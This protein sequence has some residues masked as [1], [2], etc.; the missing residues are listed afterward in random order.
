MKPKQLVYN[1]FLL[2]IAGL[3]I[4]MQSFGQNGLI[5]LWHLDGNTTDASGN[6]HNGAIVGTVTSTAG[7]FNNAYHFDGSSAID[8]GNVNLNSTGEFSVSAWV[9]S[10][11][12]YVTEVW[13]MVV[14]KLNTSTG[15]PLELFLGD[16]RSSGNPGTAGNYLAWNGG[17]SLYHAFSPYDLSRNA[18]D[19]NWH[20]L[21][22]TF[23]S[24]S[25]IVYFNGNPVGSSTSTDPLPNT[26]SNFRIG[27][28][29][30]G[31]YH[32]P[33][34]GEID[35]VSAYNRVL[36][37]AEIQ[38][39]AGN[40]TNSLVWKL[41][42]NSDAADT[43]KL[44]TT[45]AVPLNIVTNNLT[46]LRILQNGKIG[47]NTTTPATSFHVNGFGAFGNRVTSS[48]ATRA[49]NL[50]DDNAVIRVLRVH[51]T[52]AP[53]IE[54]IS[55]TSADGA[56]VAYWDLYAQP[57][58]ASFRIRDRQ[59]GTLLDRL[60]IS[61]TYGNVGIGTTSPT[62]SALL[63]VS[64]TTKGLLTPRMTQ[65][66]RNAI[67]SPAPG[68]L[69]FQTDGTAGF[70][71]YYNGWKVLVNNVAT[72]TSIALT[73]SDN[74]QV[75]QLKAENEKLWVELA[76][77]KQMVAEFKGERLGIHNPSAY[78]EQNAPNPFSNKTIIRYTLPLN[79]RSANLVILDMTG[80][81][82][83]TITLNNKG[84][85]GQVTLN[86]GTLAAG[87]YNY[88]LYIENKP[89]DTRRLVLTR[90]QKLSQRRWYHAIPP[91]LLRLAWLFLEY[92][93]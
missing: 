43:S 30:F 63:D 71:Y 31:P 7:K 77:L 17:N 88:T 26:N 69:V 22:V 76:A 21:A 56:N 10:N 67:P 38:T 28:I 24:G 59:A 48:N 5:G 50:A 84:G 85:T 27:G 57:S 32:H 18:R 33:W 29:D 20:H 1:C 80:T 54:L 53:A 68:L 61:H 16:G 60:T 23:K 78:L 2:F 9:K 45:N 49:L 87:T 93:S 52:S 75:K 55:R 12:P 66:Q 41:A 47:V 91:S 81:V 73:S 72:L 90:Q 25:Q 3:L 58:D 40:T 8:C 86:A 13:R 42:G 19:G 70:Y 36:S 15:G 37:A 11:D 6:G 34:V 4:T 92:K 62:A 83:K 44:G 89:M 65:A 82:V 79:T 35:E 46:R 74:A 14:S 51:A 64:S 39:L